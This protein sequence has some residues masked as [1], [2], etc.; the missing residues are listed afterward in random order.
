MWWRFRKNRL[1][2]VSAIILIGFYGLFVFAEFLGTGDPARVSQEYHYL[3]PQPVRFFDNGRF[4][5]HMNGIEGYT[6]T[7]TSKKN[8]VRI[9]MSDIQSG[10]SPVDTRTSS[11]GWCHSIAT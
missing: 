4:R 6:G 9:Q 11:S 3:R 10:S 1:A 8:T 7:K 2:V 5:L